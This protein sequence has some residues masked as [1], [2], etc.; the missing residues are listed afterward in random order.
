MAAMLAGVYDEHIT[1][2]HASF[3]NENPVILHM[4]VMKSG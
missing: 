2:R 3:T 4:N 1:D